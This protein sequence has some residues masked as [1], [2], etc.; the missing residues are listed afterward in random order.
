[1]LKQ[2]SHVPH[3][4]ARLSQRCPEAPSTHAGSPEP[5][6]VSALGMAPCRQP[7]ASTVFGDA[8]VWQAKTRGGLLR[9]S[10]GS[11]YLATSPQEKNKDDTRSQCRSFHSITECSRLEGTSVGHPVQPPCRSSVTQSRLHRT[12]SRWVLSIS[13][14]GEFNA[15]LAA[16]VRASHTFDKYI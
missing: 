3:H 2:D 11:Q 10:H 9:V 6:Q 5:G 16:L 7:T 12:L 14:E 1:V 13:R 15:H 8:R 4:P